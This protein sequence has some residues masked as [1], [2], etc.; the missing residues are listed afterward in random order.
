MTEAILEEKAGPTSYA[1]RTERT[2]S[3][4]LRVSVVRSGTGPDNRM[5]VKTVITDTE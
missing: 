5:D 2:V 4:L 3:E 1:V